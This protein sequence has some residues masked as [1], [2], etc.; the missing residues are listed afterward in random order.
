ILRLRHLDV[1]LGQVVGVGALT[2]LIT[3]LSG[4]NRRHIV[5]RFSGLGTL[6]RVEEPRDAERREHADDDDHHG[7]LNEGE[8]L[9]PPMTQ[10]AVHTVLHFLRPPG[11]VARQTVWKISRSYAAPRAGRS[12]HTSWTTP[13]R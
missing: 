2:D 7:Q 11:C 9:S 1:E 12:M 10:N 6:D 13:C 8:A 3:L 4:A 5:E